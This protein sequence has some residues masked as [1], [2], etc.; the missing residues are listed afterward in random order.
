MRSLKLKVL[1]LLLLVLIITESTNRFTRLLYLPIDPNLVERA[2]FQTSLFLMTLN[3]Y[4]H[5][6]KHI[7]RGHLLIEGVQ[8]QKTFKQLDAYL[9]NINNLVMGYNNKLGGKNNKILVDNVVVKGNGGWI[10]KKN[11]NGYVDGSLVMGDFSIDLDN[12]HKIKN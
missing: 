11:F 12:L 10:L 1:V 5:K 4:I 8:I 3:L 9:S 6:A 7:N 2:N